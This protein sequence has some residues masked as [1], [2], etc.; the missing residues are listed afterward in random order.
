MELLWIESDGLATE[1]MIMSKEI[2]Y[3]TNEVLVLEE[4]N[5]DLEDHVELLKGQYRVLEDQDELLADHLCEVNC[6]KAP[7]FPDG[8]SLKWSSCMK[9]KVF[10][11]QAMFGENGVIKKDDI[12]NEEIECESSEGI[13][14]VAIEERMEVIIEEDSWLMMMIL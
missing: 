4:C 6:K 3:K 12:A 14:S 1:R 10:Q 8:S 2:T 13:D 9:R 5:S 11:I 7:A